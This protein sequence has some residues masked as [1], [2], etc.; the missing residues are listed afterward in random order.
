MIR[1][2]ASL[3]EDLLSWK[4]LAAARRS[5]RSFPI[6]TD[7]WNGRM[8]SQLETEDLVDDG[9]GRSTSTTGIFSAPG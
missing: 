2:R 4:L 1:C 7:S 9:E 5:D 6:T 8:H 3:S